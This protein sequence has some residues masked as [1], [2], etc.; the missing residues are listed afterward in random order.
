MHWATA[1]GFDL[2]APHWDELTPELRVAISRVVHNVTYA[3]THAAPAPVTDALVD[4]VR[5]MILDDELMAVE[6]GQPDVFNGTVGEIIDAR[7]RTRL[8]KALSVNT[9][10]GH[11]PSAE[12]GMTIGRASYLMAMAILQSEL[13]RGGDDELRAAV[14]RSL[15]QSLTG[16]AARPAAAPDNQKRSGAGPETI[17]PAAAGQEGP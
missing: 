1:R 15:P 3:L 7:I 14:D 10:A 5:R 13:Y 4:C 6:V 16:R 12:A 8:A 11:A 17:T 2:K 9:S